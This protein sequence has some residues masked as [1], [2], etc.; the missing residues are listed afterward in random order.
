MST[1]LK[2]VI[3]YQKC[4]TCKANR[5]CKYTFRCSRACVGLI[6]VIMENWRLSRTNSKTLSGNTRIFSRIHLKRMPILHYENARPTQARKPGQY[7][8]LQLNLV[9]FDIFFCS[10]T[11]R[12]GQAFIFGYKYHSGSAERFCPNPNFT[13]TGFKKSS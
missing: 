13:A 11:L 4:I 6:V 5:S 8:T 12:T 7:K 1:K 3:F 10:I 9:L 2:K